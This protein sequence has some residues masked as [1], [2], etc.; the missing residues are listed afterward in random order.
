MSLERLRTIATK[1]DMAVRDYP[2]QDDQGRQVPSLLLKHGS[3]DLLAIDNGEYVLIMYPIKL[4]PEHTAAL[5]RQSAEI[6]SRLFAILRREMMEGRSGYRLE[7]EDPPANTRLL[8]ISVEQKVVIA[9]TDPVTMQRVADGVQE[10]VLI[11]IRG[12]SVLAKTFA[13]QAAAAPSSDYH[14]NMYA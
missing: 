1:L 8:G 13:V 5:A 2:L 6:R 7:Y 3:H 10:L 12:G 9:D 14:P 11:G 4:K